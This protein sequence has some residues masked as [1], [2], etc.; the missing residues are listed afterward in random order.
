MAALGVL[1]IMS[2]AGGWLGA[3][4]GAADMVGLVVIQ[5][6][7]L[8]DNNQIN[9]LMEQDMDFLVADN[10]DIMVA[11][12]AVVQVALVQMDTLLREEQVG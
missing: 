5:T 8:R 6:M 4:L 7:S 3:L 9:H 10:S 1:V 2:M 11:E 12:A